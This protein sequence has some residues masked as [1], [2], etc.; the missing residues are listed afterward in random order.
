MKAMRLG[1]RYCDF[2]GHGEA[3]SDECYVVRRVLEASIRI[4]RAA[5]VLVDVWDSHYL[6]GPKERADRIVAERLAPLAE[7]CRKA[8]I[9]VVH[10]PAREAAV[11]Y[12]KWLEYAGDEEIRGRE[13][14]VED[15]AWPPKDF[16]E[17]REEYAWLAKPFAQGPLLETINR[18]DREQRI[19]PAMEPKE[20]DFVVVSGGQLHRLCRHRGLL[21]LFYAGFNTNMCVLYRDY[22]LRA[23]AHRGYNCVLVRDCTTGIEAAE[24]IDGLR[25]TE[26]AIWDVEMMHGFT[27]TSQ[28]IVGAIEAV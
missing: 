15:E 17:R 4:D 16:R 7:A 27:V 6:V 21:H 26:A 14:V 9:T 3:M 20:S 12:R 23:M 11:K 1:L 2:Y 5:L 13:H 28:E 25:L 19:T 8:G 10:A 18:N 22:G 24:T